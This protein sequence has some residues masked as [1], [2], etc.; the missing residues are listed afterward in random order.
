MK[1]ILKSFNSSD[2]YEYEIDTLL[3]KSDISELE[4]IN[5]TLFL[6]HPFE[7][8][9][10]KIITGKIV[11]KKKVSSSAENNFPIEIQ[12][13]KTSS[14]NEYLKLIQQAIETI[15]LS[16]LKKVVISR[17]LNLMLNDIPNWGSYLSELATNYPTAAIYLFEYHGVTWIGATPEQLVHA[18]NGS[19]S[20]A[21][22]AGTISKTTQN[23]KQW[24]KKEYEEQQIVTDEIERILSELGIEFKTSETY[25]IDTG[26]LLH[27]KS[28]ITGNLKSHQELTELISKLHPTPA[29]CGLPKNKAKDFILKNENYQREYYSGFFGFVN[30]SEISAELYVNLRCLKATDNLVSIFAGGGITS[31]SIAENEWEETEAKLR[32][33]KSPF[34]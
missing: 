2:F 6:F 30:F 4:S 19:F 26:N 7:K 23:E 16:N 25:Q 5:E 31:S 21:S 18:K 17:P 24:T 3:N 12:S 15:K 11:G 13:Q 20:V 9:H 14:K 33:L 34:I 28:D 1:F 32:T 29:T 8:S 22:L 27:L 10:E